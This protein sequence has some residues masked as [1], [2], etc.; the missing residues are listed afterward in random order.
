MGFWQNV[1]DEC[2]YL[3][4]SRKELAKKADFSVHTISNGIRRDGM[5]AADLALRISKALDV[6]LEKL[7]DW[8]ENIEPM[9]S[10]EQIQNQKLLLKYLP[11]LKKINEM[12]ADSKRAVV[13]IIEKLG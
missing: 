9:E 12:D 6:P 1:E 8:N 7:L 10:P 4:I 3:G 5:P 11:I 13:T 2:E